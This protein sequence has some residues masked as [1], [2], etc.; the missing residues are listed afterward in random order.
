ML[1]RMDALV[2]GEVQRKV[3]A[4][5][6]FTLPRPQPQQPGRQDLADLGQALGGRHE[7]GI[8]GVAQS[9]VSVGAVA[10]PPQTA[11]AVDHR[12]GGG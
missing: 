2:G 9:A 11:F 3:S 8:E 10:E 4:G 7:T 5:V 12:Q 1:S 6:G